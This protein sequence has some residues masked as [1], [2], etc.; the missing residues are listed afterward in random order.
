MIEMQSWVCS[1]VD[2]CKQSKYWNCGTSTKCLTQTALSG[3]KGRRTQQQASTSFIPPTL[4]RPKLSR[5]NRIIDAMFI[6]L[7]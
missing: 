3:T 4:I 5:D 7:S 1:G 2:L 6:K